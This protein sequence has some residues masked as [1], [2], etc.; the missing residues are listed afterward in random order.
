MTSKDDDDY[1]IIFRR[2]RRTKSGAMLDARKF[3]IAAW[4]IKVR[5]AKE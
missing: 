3:G 1:V 5:K 2:F 4:P